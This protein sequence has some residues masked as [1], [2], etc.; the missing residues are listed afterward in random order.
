MIFQ[1][2]LDTDDDMFELGLRI[3]EDLKSKRDDDE[4]SADVA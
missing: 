3:I 2:M 1:L 4:D